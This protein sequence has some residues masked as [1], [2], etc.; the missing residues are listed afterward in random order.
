MTLTNE[1]EEREKQYRQKGLISYT[2]YDSPFVNFVYEMQKKYPEELFNIQGISNKSR[3]LNEFSRKFF[4]KS[5]NP[6]AD[7]TADQNANVNM[8]T[9]SQYST[10]QNKANQRLNGLFLIWKYLIKLKSSESSESEDNIIEYANSCIESVINGEI[11]VNDLVSI[12]KPYCWA[13][14]LGL[15]TFEGMKFLNSNIKVGKPKRTDSFISLVIQS[16]AYISNQ[17]AGAIAFPDFFVYLDWYLRKEFGE[18]YVNN[19]SKEIEDKFQHFIYSCNFEFRTGQSCFVNLSILDRSFLN[20]LFGELVYSDMTKP[21]IE[22]TYK[23]GKWFF[24][25]FNSIYMTE[26]IFTF[27]VITLA[28]GVEHGKYLDEEF[29]NWICEVNTEKALGNIYTGEPSSLSSCCRLRSDVTKTKNEY[30]NSFGVGGAS[31]G[32]HRVIGINLPRLYKDC[33]NGEIHK[34]EFINEFNI[35][36][37]KIRNMLKAHRNIVKHNIEVGT[38][39]LYT[40]DWMILDKQYSTIGIIGIYE[41]QQYYNKYAGIEDKLNFDFT[42]DLMKHLNNNIEVWK[43]NDSCIYNVEQIP[44]ESLAY[45]LAA[46]DKIFSKNEEYEFYSNQYFPLTINSIKISDRFKVQGKFDSKTSGGAIL[47]IN[48]DESEK[49]SPIQ[50][51]ILFDYAIKTK[52]VY[53]AINYIYISCSNGHNFIGNNKTEK[54]PICESSDLNYYTRVVGFIT[55]TKHWVAVRREYDFPNRK[56]YNKIG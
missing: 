46:V 49:I 16:M 1:S 38:L 4:S 35:R 2:S 7:L 50:M 47:H 43:E 55:N 45:R 51:K 21:N 6:T 56:F 52:C 11:F 15:L 23:L 25:F 24:E 18:D 27:P 10:E 54:C 44:G 12:E 26:G 41:T 19:K 53:W 9:V 20:N 17:I 13:Q 31:I 48:I 30:Q 39:P 40:Y 8:K 34:Q 37:N 32:S 42:L 33:M 14:S 3:D 5:A 28:C 29:V 22:S 36:L